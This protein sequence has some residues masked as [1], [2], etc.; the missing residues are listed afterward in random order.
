MQDFRMSMLK[1][2]KHLLALCEAVVILM[3]L[4]L[5][6]PHAV[7]AE[8]SSNKVLVVGSEEEYPPFSIGY[9]DQTADGF[10]VELWKAVAAKSQL[11]YVIHVKPF[12][13]LLMD[14]KSGHVDVL[15]NLAQSDERKQFVDF[16][17]PH[18]TV[19]GGI[20]IR[21]SS[22]EIRSERDL[23]GKEI[24][25][26]NGD[27]AQNY[28][29]TQPWGAHLR[30][31]DSASEAFNL[32]A[33]GKHDAIVISKLAGEKT[34]KQLQ[35]DNVKLV[36]ANVGF[37]Q[38]FSF[39]VA[40]GNS[41]LLAKINEGLA[42]VKESGE[43]DAIY[44]KWFAIYHLD[45]PLFGN[46][47][48][49]S[50]V[51]MVLAIL[52]AIYLFYVRATE[53]RQ[54]LDLI[55]EANKNFE[56]VL[57][58]ASQFSIIA[59]DLQGLITTFNSGAHALLGH[60]AEEVVGKALI[61]KLHNRAELELRRSKQ[62][63]YFRRSLSEFDALVFKSL[64]GEYD[65]FECEYVSING[66]RVPVIVNVSP[67]KNSDDT[68][69][70]FL[71]IAQDITDR[72]K[73]E[74]AQI[75]YLDKLRQSEAHKSAILECAPDAIM[76]MNQDGHFVE[77][78][79]A[80]EKMFDYQRAEVIGR[81]VAD[82]IMHPGDRARHEEGMKAYIKS[83]KSTILGRRV[84][85]TGMRRGGGELRLEMIVVPFDLDD[86]HH[87]LAYARDVTNKD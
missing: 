44:N 50:I 25:V 84:T 16:T 66:N 58:A 60:T 14:I 86:D 63:E 1:L 30:L 62:S 23:N 59:T 53:R 29:F 20:F 80:A 72:K 46:A 83:G 78:N 68:V 26:I 27:L 8:V 5:A 21:K 47:F 19:S 45:P 11:A 17:V 55:R 81:K 75:Q 48:Y 51:F 13:S 22:N 38:K 79:P 36:D 39:A 2:C 49:I 76:I 28:A 42:L 24:I 7:Q 6:L 32:L 77:F 61:I 64:M 67:V 57:S 73:L 15:I 9:T 34:I 10:T 43:Y 65:K 56:S 87:F 12:K 69:I 41:D 35:I 40:K 82:M 74:S 3:T 52:V 85:L 31:V 71:F 70:G 37:Q 4:C 54:S 33:S 18:V